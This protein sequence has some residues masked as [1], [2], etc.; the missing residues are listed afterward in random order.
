MPIMNSCEEKSKHKDSAIFNKDADFPMT[1]KART[2][3]V[4]SLNPPITTTYTTTIQERY[5]HIKDKILRRLHHEYML[6]MQSNR[7]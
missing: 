7:D 6:E 4:V 3:E 1:K 5:P 2:S